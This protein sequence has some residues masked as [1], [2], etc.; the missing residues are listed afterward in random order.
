MLGA[1]QGKTHGY[2][3]SKGS[4]LNLLL[5]DYVILTNL[6]A[7][8]GFNETGDRRELVQILARFSLLMLRAKALTPR[9]VEQIWGSNPIVQR[10]LS[11]TQGNLALTRRRLISMAIVAN[12][13]FHLWLS[14]LFNGATIIPS[15]NLAHVLLRVRDILNLVG[16][17]IFAIYVR[18]PLPTG[19]D[20]IDILLNNLQS[21]SVNPTS[22]TLEDVIVSWFSDLLLSCDQATDDTGIDNQIFQAYGLSP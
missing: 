13:T 1:R 19:Q 22:T 11:G 18:E 14:T 3:P 7:V 17:N 16:N 4:F 8:F 20:C 6:T 2:R 9:I 10:N 21:S 5:C 12:N 15:E